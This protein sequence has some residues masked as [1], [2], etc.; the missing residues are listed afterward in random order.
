MADFQRIVSDSKFLSGLQG[1]QFLLANYVQPRPPKQRKGPGRPVFQLPAA[2]CQYSLYIRLNEM[3][4]EY[5]DSL[6][7]G[8]YSPANIQ[9]HLLKADFHGALLT[10]WKASCTSYVGQ[11]GIVIHETLRSFRMITQ[12]NKVK[13]FLKQDAVFSVYIGDKLVKV[14]G[15]HFQYRPAD[16]IK[17][18]WT[19]RDRIKLFT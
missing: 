6:L 5:I 16:R 15:E 13:T 3:W 17:A 8:N 18:K 1:R 4:V 10:V 11:Q 7:K 9:E 14:Y 2:E 12:E 19:R